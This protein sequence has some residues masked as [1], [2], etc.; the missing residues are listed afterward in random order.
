MS[1]GRAG[2]LAGCLDPA[3]GWWGWGS[4]AAA[5]VASN[6]A[7]GC[8]PLLQV[9]RGPHVC[10]WLG[11]LLWLLLEWVLLHLQQQG[12]PLEEELL[13]PRRT[14]QLFFQ[15][16]GGLGCATKPA[17]THLSSNAIR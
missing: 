14:A 12:Q 6:A 8:G 5:A 4:K 13:L 10:Q 11:V 17:H 16:L 1:E 7:V 9:R 2:M 3:T 15:W